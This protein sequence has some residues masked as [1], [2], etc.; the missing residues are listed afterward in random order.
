MRSGRRVRDHQVYKSSTRLPGEVDT[1]NLTPKRHS[2]LAG[3]HQ[4]TIPLQ[5]YL[6]RHTKALVVDQALE[7]VMQLLYSRPQVVRRAPQV[8][9][10]SYGMGGRSGCCPE[11]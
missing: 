9:P 8:V 2:T 3:Y 1:K 4:T 10:G 7:S 11:E 6:R 5:V